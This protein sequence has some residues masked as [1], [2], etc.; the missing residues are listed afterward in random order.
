[1]TFVP[2][3]LLRRLLPALAA[4]LAAAAPAAAAEKAPRPA[5][6]LLADSDTKI[7]LF[8]TTHILP[9]RLKWRSAALDRAIAEAD[10]LVMETADSAEGE[11]EFSEAELK[12]MLRAT[13][14]PVLE[15]VSQARR[16]P[17][18]KLIAEAEMPIE[19]M[20]AF[21]DWAVAMLLTVSQIERHYKKSG[22]K[23]TGAEEVLGRAFRK[24][25]KR[26]SGIET[27][28]EQMGFLAAVSAE[29]QKA[30][31]EDTIDELSAGN[32]DALEGDDEAWARGDVEA[33]AASIEGSLPPEVYDVLLPQRNARWTEWLAKRLERPGTLLF[34]VGAG[35]L[36]GKDSVQRMLAARG[37]RA[38]RID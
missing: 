25:G 29:T 24:A 32:L 33:I 1:M 11:A 28:A 16:A 10:E 23:V 26:V 36:A 13:P 30:M 18:R 2:A 3:F 19:V 8:G 5:L 12:P 6:W 31:L 34:A 7:Y 17:L 27:G 4:L 14:A 9:A 15:R 37:L 38:R 21:Q 35:H 20:D 22:D